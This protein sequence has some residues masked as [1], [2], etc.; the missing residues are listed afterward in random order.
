MHIKRILLFLFGCIQTRLLL[1]YIAKN[2]LE[3]LPYMGLFAIAISI[4]FM[5]IY[6][7]KLRD[8]GPEVFGDVIWWD[9]LRP[10]HSILWGS[11]AYLAFINNK[12][13]W[14]ILLLDTLFGLLSYIIW[15]TQLLKI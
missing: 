12:D 8:T 2:Y 5:C 10:I 15:Q 13:A 4:G 11:F 7:F 3:L 9:S 14:K 6:I 1:S